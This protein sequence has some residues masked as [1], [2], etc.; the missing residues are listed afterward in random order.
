MREDEEDASVTVVTVAGITLYCVEAPWV[1]AIGSKPAIRKLAV[2]QKQLGRYAT[3]GTTTGLAQFREIVAPGLILAKHVFR[4]LKRPMAVGGNM[5][6]DRDKLVYSWK[7]V[8]DYEWP[9]NQFR[10]PPCR[11]TPPAGRVFVV[12]V[13]PNS[14]N[15]FPE[16]A[17]WI[18]R[19]NWV[20]ES[21]DLPC[22]PIEHADRYEE[23]L[24]RGK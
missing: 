4:G 14:S 8:Y 5:Y 20:R 1:E 7:P 22:A 19:W 3:M 12:V 24:W 17:G 10:E 6:A 2:T 15:Q 9:G 13:T 18:E 16:V 21:T 11:L 23:Q